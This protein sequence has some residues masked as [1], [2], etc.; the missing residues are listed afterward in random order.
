MRARQ[1][2]LATP[3]RGAPTIR[4]YSLLPLDNRWCCWT[5]TRPLWNEPRPEL[6][7][8]IDGETRIFVT[9]MNAERPNENV[10]ALVTRTLPDY[11]LLRPNVVA[12]PVR[13]HGASGAAPNLL[14]AGNEGRAHANL[15]AMARNYLSRLNLANPDGDEAV[16]ELIWS[17]ALAICYSP[18]YLAENE[19][20]VKRDFPRIPLPPSAEILQASARL[21]GQV[22]DLL[23]P[24]QDVPGVTS[25]NI[26]HGLRP[27]GT[28]IRAP[29]QRGAI[30][31]RLT[32][33]WGYSG[34]A[35]VIMPGG[36]RI[37]EH[38]SWPNAEKFESTLRTAVGTATD[39]LS[40][41]G[42]PLDVF[43][44]DDSYWTL[45]PSAVWE[46][47][48]G[49]Y[50]VLKKWLSYRQHE[51]LG[52]PLTVEESRHVTNMVRRLTIIVL[53]SDELNSNYKAC[54]AW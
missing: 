37:V 46:Y 6:V 23:D 44:N 14:S 13:L 42:A 32:A 25:G 15:S 3:D 7:G 48:I 54:R 17:H 4:R 51:L 47:R 5:G 19:D 43:L 30:D 21:G 35:G 34:R 40:A 12:I 8:W 53:L 52:R 24:D 50:Q 1:R 49:G 36:G 41:L 39:P 11:H 10:P 18:Q 9:R 16:G 31:L 33:P 26:A 20:A 2:I 29:H 38:A 45:V 22:A 28:I 27:L